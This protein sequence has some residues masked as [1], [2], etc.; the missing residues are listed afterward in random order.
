MVSP[1]FCQFH[2]WISSKHC[3]IETYDLKATETKLFEEAECTICLVKFSLTFWWKESEDFL[4]VNC[5]SSSFTFANTLSLLLL[6]LLSSPPGV[7]PLVPP[8]SW[9]G[10]T[11][12]LNLHGLSAA[13]NLAW[14][15][16]NNVWPGVGM[17]IASLA[18]H[19]PCKVLGVVI[20]E[21]RLSGQGYM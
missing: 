3:R 10:E 4:V 20:N 13:P 7:L 8:L 16:I 5:F 21:I 18:R 14:R 9:R 17:L 11:L 1:S 19:K 15:V 12:T 2:T 6:V